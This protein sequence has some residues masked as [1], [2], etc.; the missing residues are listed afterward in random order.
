MRDLATELENAPKLY[1]ESGTSVNI[2]RWILEN[3]KIEKK[4]K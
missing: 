2:A 4:Q 1:F 3:Y